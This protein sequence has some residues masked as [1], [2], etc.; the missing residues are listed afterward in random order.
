[1]LI[2]PRDVLDFL[3][4]SMFQLGLFDWLSRRRLL[5]AFF[6]RHPG[7]ACRTRPHHGTFSLVEKLEYAA[8]LWGNLVMIAS[9][10]LLWKPGWFLGWLPS[11]AFDLG[12]VVHGYEATLAFLAIIVWHMYHVHLRPEVFPMSR[13]W[14]TGKITRE[15]LRHHHTRKYLRLL[16]QRRSAVRDVVLTPAEPQREP[17]DER[18]AGEPSRPTRRESR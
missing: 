17:P 2:R 12:R 6:E 13:I 4:E 11:W 5:A 9:G 3:Q 18:S 8:V 7:L 1:M 16:E 14:L 15:E 10:T